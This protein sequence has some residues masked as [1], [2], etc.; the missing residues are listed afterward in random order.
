M[1][2]TNAVDTWFYATLGADSALMTAVNGAAINKLFAEQ[3]RETAALPY[4]I[5]SFLSGTDLMVVGSY[6]VWTNAL[7][8]VRGI[9]ETDSFGGNLKTIAD[10]ID[11]VLHAASGS[12]V[13]GII[14]AC[15]RESPFRMVENRDGRTSLRHLGGIYRIFAKGS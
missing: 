14:Y 8:V 3:A 13:N 12:N 4:V 5:W 6:R 10:R 9:A 7:F 1:S 15:V 2:E 11:T